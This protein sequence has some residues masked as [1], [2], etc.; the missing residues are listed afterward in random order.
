MYIQDRLTLILLD[1]VMMVLQDLAAQN[2]VVAVVVLAVMV[3]AALVVLV[4]LMI[5]H[6]VQQ[7]Q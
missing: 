7:I 2:M 4:L 1:R 5:M 3:L 6:M